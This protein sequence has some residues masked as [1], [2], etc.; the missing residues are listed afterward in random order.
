MMENDDE[1]LNIEKNKYIETLEENEENKI[2]GGASIRTETIYGKYV[3][4][5]PPKNQSAVIVVSFNGGVKRAMPSGYWENGWAFSYNGARNKIWVRRKS[6]STIH[7]I[8]IYWGY[9]NPK[10]TEYIASVSL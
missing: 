7:N 10:S 8:D 5:K 3:N 1:N 2:E 4:V 6:T 9:N